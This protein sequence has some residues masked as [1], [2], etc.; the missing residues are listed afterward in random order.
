M[1]NIIL[2]IIFSLIALDVQGATYYVRTDGGTDAECDGTHD[3]ALS[4]ATDSGD[5]GSIPDCAYSHP[6]YAKRVEGESTA[7]LLSGG[8][9]LIIDGTGGASYAMGADAPATGGS[10]CNMTY[11][12]DC[13][14]RIPAGPSAGNPT[15]I[16]GKGWDT[17]TGTKPKLS[18]QNGIYR[19]IIDL[20]DVDNI[21][22]QYL[23]ITDNENC[24]I[25]SGG[26]EGS[27]PRPCSGGAR[28]GVYGRGD[29]VTTTDKV[30]NV[31]L[32]NLNIH[33]LSYAGIMMAGAEDWTF[34]NVI[35]RANGFNGV[36]GDTE[37]SDSV[38][39]QL[40]TMIVRN[41]EVSYSG[42]SETTGGAVDV[43]VGQAGSNGSG[44]AYYGG[45]GDAF[46][47][48][49]TMADWDIEGLKCNY[50]N[51]D[52]F[53]ALHGSGTGYLK[54]TNSEFI[55]NT[56]QAVKSSNALTLENSVVIDDCSM[57]LYSAYAINN[58]GTTG[59]SISSCR[60]D[61][62]I[63]LGGGD[64]KIHKIINSTLFSN[65]DQVISLQ[66]DSCS[67]LQVILRN[68]IVHGGREFYQDS[69]VLGIYKSY[70]GGPGNGYG[71][72]GVSDTFYSYG[73]C[74]ISLTEDHN[75][76]W[77]TKDGSSD[78]T[79]T[80]SVYQNPGLVGTIKT[81]P[82]DTV[83][84]YSSEVENDDFYLSS[85]SQARYEVRGADTADETLVSGTNGDL[86]EDYNYFSRGSNWDT[87]ALEYGS[88][89]S[90][91]GGES[92]GNGKNIS[93]GVRISGGL[94]L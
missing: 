38:D 31:L 34:E 3:A 72:D 85:T 91:G 74:S 71:D 54:I 8:D 90:G 67:G 57:L 63:S 15:R 92:S 80:G 61:S 28:V 75:I 93:G 14:W 32:K 35:V 1:K 51:A 58:P 48:Y 25:Q 44:G 37:Y 55:G 47:S 79:G 73:G 46:V 70:G 52:C 4:G 86:S 81:G 18:G 2:I 13:E 65:H 40:G 68:S 22:I 69:G 84:Y 20:F 76:F 82:E 64:N 83:G 60:A 59:S 77:N 7:G 49:G 56:G 33:G 16:L 36:D 6:Y 62:A 9:T 17:V 19:G 24:M 66:S 50:N 23:E 88:T 5:A 41:M 30:K 11:P 10:G 87:G 26:V 53:D 39:G 29:T 43:C 89:P 94:R 42:C 21:E 12:A 45:Q 78:A 27:N